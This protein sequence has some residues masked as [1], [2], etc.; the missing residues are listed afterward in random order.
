MFLIKVHQNMFMAHINI[1]TPEPGKQTFTSLQL[2][3]QEFVY[4]E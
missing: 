3:P 1:S 2:R 4:P